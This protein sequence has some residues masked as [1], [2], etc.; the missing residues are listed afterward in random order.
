MT[1]WIDVLRQE[2]E[3]NSLRTVGAKIGYSS[4][5]V[6]LVLKGT[7]KGDLKAVEKAVTLKLMRSSI[8]CPVLGEIT[9]SDCSGHQAKPF[10]SASSASVRLYRACRTCPFNTKRKV[11]P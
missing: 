2:C 8:P 4:A 3:G 9:A 11:A 5:T 1:G 10:T 7:Y 6:S